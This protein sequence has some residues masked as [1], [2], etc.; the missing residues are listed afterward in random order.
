MAERDRSD[1]FAEGFQRGFALD[2]AVAFRRL[3]LDIY[4][5]RCAVTGKV[6][7]RDEA[8]TDLEVFLFQPLVHGGS[9]SPRNAIVVD[10]VVAGL[11]GKG[12]ILVSDTYK[13]YTLHP[14]IVGMP[15][16]A[17]DEHGRNMA[18]PENVSLWP[19]PT[20]VSYHRSLFRAQ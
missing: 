5:N 13:A 20:M 18:L 2:D 7:A 16:E 14:E 4:G 12:H 9:M 11:L 3:M 10:T 8:D 17:G 15:V 19:A 1:G 6:F